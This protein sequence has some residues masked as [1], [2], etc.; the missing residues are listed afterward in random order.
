MM[1]RSAGIFG[2]IC[3]ALLGLGLP[4]ED[5]R[6]LKKLRMK[7]GEERF[8]HEM[9]EATKALV[10]DAL[11]EVSRLL[12]AAEPEGFGTAGGGRLG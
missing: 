6:G 5:V 10:V 2:L 7:F 4:A 3:Q 9:L 1:C 11:T 12:E 8:P